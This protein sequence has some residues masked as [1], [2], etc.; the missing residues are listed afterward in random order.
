M[1]IKPTF[2]SLHSFDVMSFYINKT[3]SYS[4]NRDVP[5]NNFSYSNFSLSSLL[6]KLFPVDLYGMDNHPNDLIQ[7]FS[8]IDI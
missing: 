4:D 8:S 5:H 3:S 7:P 2:S 6:L 1:K